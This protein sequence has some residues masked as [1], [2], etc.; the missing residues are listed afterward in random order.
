MGSGHGHGLVAVGPGLAGSMLLAGGYGVNPLP[1]QPAK[2]HCPPPRD[3]TLSRERLN[4]WLERAASGRLALIVAEAGFGKTTLLADWALHTGRM[5]AWYRLEQDDRDWLTF[6]RH[7]VASVR[8]LDPEFAPETFGLLLALGSGGPT[9]Q[10]L[11]ASLAREVAA[12]GV[13]STR[14]LTLIL[15]DYHVVDGFVETEPIVRALL[16]RTAPGFSVVIST[17]S[18]P[19]FP[20]GRLRARGGVMTLEGADLCFDI[21]ETTRLFRDAYHRPL[22][23]DVV[24]DLFDRTE[25]WAALLT[26]VR[27]GLD[28]R[29]HN[30]PRV[31]V[32]HLD[33]SRGDLYDFLAEE[34]LATLSPDLQHFLTRV[35]LLMSVD[36]ERAMLVHDRPAEDIAAAIAEC[37]RLGLLTRP[38]RES[39]HRFHPLVREFLV[40]HLTAE[41]GEAVVM[42][43]HGKLG[44]SLTSV[45]WRES[46]WHFLMARDRL[47]CQAVVDTNIDE[48][49]AADESEFARQFLD[50]DAGDPERPAAFILRSRVEF[51]RGNIERALHWAR[52]AAQRAGRGPFAGAAQLNLL[53]V[54]GIGGVVDEAIDV[55]RAA[56]ESELRPSQRY[57]A[58]ASVALLEASEEGDLNE[59]ADGL[60][61]LAASQER[62]RYLRYAGISR[63]NLAGILLWLGDAEQALIQGGKAELNLGGKSNTSVE[64]VAA[65]AIRAVA[66]AQVGHLAESMDVLA[67]A[68]ARPSHLTRAE[69]AAE[70]S[71]IGAEFGSVADAEAALRQGDPERL[72]G[73]HQ[74]YFFLIAGQV[75]LRR[76]DL[77]A[78]RAMID[79]LA[80]R[81]CADAAGKFR[82]QVLRTRVA[83]AAG[84]SDAEKHAREATRIA[85]AQGSPLCKYLAAL[86]SCLATGQSVDELVAQAHPNETY[87][88][89]LLA[90][91]LASNLESL[92]PTSK[93]LV[94]GEARRR[95]ERWRSALRMAVSAGSRGAAEAAGVLA[96]IGS[97]EDGA[98]L[99]AVGASKKAIRPHALAIT[100]R[101]A[102]PVFVSDLGV[103]EVRIG[104]TALPRGLR[105]KVLAL[106]CFLSSR[107][108]MAA[109][110]DEALDAL[111]PDL[112]P[113]TGGNSLHQAIYFMRRVFEPDFREGMNA[114][115]ISVDGDI[116]SLNPRLVD[117]ASRECWRLLQQARKGSEQ[118]LDQVLQ[119]YVGRYALD[120][121]YDDWS[122]SYRENL[123]AAVLAAAEAD[124]VRARQLR[125]FDRAIH[126][127]HAVLAIDPQADSIELELLK[128]YKSSGRH[129]AAAEQYAHYAAFVRNELAAD[130]PSYDDI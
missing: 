113:D 76:G 110:R 128:A 100:V 29:G 112:S 83:I 98:L 57:V 68:S 10:D 20:M 104:E 27:T 63:L 123:H 24:S 61:A 109:N 74:G 9:Q 3:D 85:H 42:E 107:A 5:T 47:A 92:S 60:F 45:N 43:L 8:E 84:D 79:R 26:L 95:P 86:L 122:S 59:I 108:G 66:L 37:E 44:T 105:R 19:K 94:L 7:I 69:V 119:A 18:M 70:A 13:G 17:R 55:A 53:A 91:E 33:A 127:G 72:S 35:A 80:Q 114:G 125:D 106:L 89:S 121:A 96:E 120:F 32:A 103:V 2:I 64:R 115:Y 87:C 58:L 97:S 30:D 71:R 21:D 51:G 88:W 28:D 6:I 15:D 4:S 129:A 31:L 102:K 101:L 99:R 46:A 14:G 65:T 77:A 23:E 116:V 130:P 93:A 36:V 117:C 41:I 25:G 56:L 48:I 22:D 38:D 1:V 12:F 11:V 34:V 16:D 50:V 81:R 78:A 54:L 126:L 49:L 90:E 52:T 67:Q 82:S 40:A 75:A 39:P 73:G 124:L 118:A 62:D 111:W